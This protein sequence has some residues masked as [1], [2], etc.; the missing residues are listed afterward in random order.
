MTIKGQSSNAYVANPLHVAIPMELGQPLANMKQSLSHMEHNMWVPKQ[1]IHRYNVNLEQQCN[2]PPV[3]PS[4]AYLGC[5]AWHKSEPDFLDYHDNMFDHMGLPAWSV[6]PP[7]TLHCVTDVEPAAKHTA[8]PVPPLPL[9]QAH[10]IAPQHALAQ[11]ANSGLHSCCISQYE[12]A[13]VFESNS[14]PDLPNP[15]EIVPKDT[16]RKPIPSL[17]ATQVDASCKN[18]PKQGHWPWTNKDIGA[19]IKGVTDPDHPEN[20]ELT[21]LKGFGT[22]NKMQWS[23]QE[24]SEWKEIC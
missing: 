3:V 13:A 12:T 22:H 5:C 24:V 14:K 15:L 20:F 11:T 6:S 10:G 2:V 7:G 18:T 8:L 1:P 23:Q 4:Q 16:A 21:Q 9:N 19:L 17:A